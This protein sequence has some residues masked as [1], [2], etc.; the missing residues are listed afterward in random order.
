MK[1]I[2]KNPKLARY[3]VSSIIVKYLLY[4][5]NYKTKKIFQDVDSS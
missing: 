5:F 2:R 4:K 1:N 3:Y